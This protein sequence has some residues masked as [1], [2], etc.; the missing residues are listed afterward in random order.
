MQVKVLEQTVNKVKMGS[1][2]SEMVK[3]NS[4]LTVNA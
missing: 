3:E 2:L 1:D 4:E